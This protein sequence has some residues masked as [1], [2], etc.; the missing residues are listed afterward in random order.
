M[1]SKRRFVLTIEGTDDED[2]EEIPLINRL[3]SWLKNGKRQFGLRCVSGREER[4]EA[5][6]MPVDAMDDDDLLT[7]QDG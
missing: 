5:G 3:R 7:H 2:L 1:T 6:G 4:V